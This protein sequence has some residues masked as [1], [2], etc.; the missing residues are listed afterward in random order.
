MSE[1][2]FPKGKCVKVNSMTL[3]H[4]VLKMCEL[5]EIPVYP[6]SKEM[7]LK[8][9]FD[10]T[11]VRFNGIEIARTEDLSGKVVSIEEYFKHYLDNEELPEM[12]DYK[13]RV[14]NPKESRKVQEHAFSLGCEWKDS[15]PNITDTDKKYL[16]VDEG[17]IGHG[18]TEGFFR[19]QSFQELTVEQ[20]L[21]LKITNQN[22][23]NTNDLQ[24]DSQ[25]NSGAVRGRAIRIK[26]RKSKAATGRRPDGNQA[27]YRERKRKATGGTTKGAAFVLKDS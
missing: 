1:Y 25:P 20:F 18:E 16:F 11:R 10:K 9:E 23:K 13:I 14:A 4:K 3:V 5:Y 8:G 6:Y 2:K 22:V 26:R 24:A 12:G 19:R 17:K 7:L 15:G 27:S 21:N